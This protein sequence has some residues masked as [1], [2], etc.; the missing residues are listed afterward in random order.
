MAQKK[1]ARW[2]KNNALG[3]IVSGRSHLATADK[4]FDRVRTIA[5][6]HPKDQLPIYMTDTVPKDVFFP[7]DEQ[8]IR[9]TLAKLPKEDVKGITHIW[10]RKAKA[11]EF[12]NGRIPLAEY[13][14]IDGV[15]LIAFY[16]WPEH[17]R[18][19]LTKKLPDA[20]LNRYRRWSPTMTSHK[21][22]WLL[23]WQ[24]DSV[25]DFCL[26]DL[27]RHQVAVH[28]AFTAKHN[29]KMSRQP[30]IELPVQYANQSYIEE[31]LEIW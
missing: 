2:E 19:P 1:Q 3:G 7:I 20:I 30:L 15:N 11:S 17:M 16:P 26:S 25:K 23:E 29:A 10:L 4:V 5:A 18:M 8:D 27:I 24:A 31:N 9:D 21:G 28:I 13:I 12:R 14:A 22:K 6:P